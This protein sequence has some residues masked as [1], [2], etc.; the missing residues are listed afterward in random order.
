MSEKYETHV[1]S[2]LSECPDADPEEIAAAFEKYETEFFIPPQDAMR[3]I[4]RRFKG[5]KTPKPSSGSSGGSS[6]A[7]RNTRKVSSLSELKGDDKDI[8]GVRVE[9]GTPASHQG[10]VS[11]TLVMPE[12]RRFSASEFGQLW[13][14]RIG[15]PAKLTQLAVDFLQGPGNGRDLTLELAHLDPLVSRKAA[16]TARGFAMI[17]AHHALKALVTMGQSRDPHMG[18]CVRCDKLGR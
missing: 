4:L 7:P 1:K 16:D 8:E 10:S 15:Q 6:A 14:D 5:D 9:M 12:A 13:R 3:S 11:F 18:K 17:F 2:I